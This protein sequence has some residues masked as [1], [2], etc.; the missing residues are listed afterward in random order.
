MSIARVGILGAG[1]WGTALA[2]S[3]IRAGSSVVLWT[4]AEHL[5]STI[6]QE[7]ENP[8]Y[9][10]GVALDAGIRATTDLAE[11]AACEALLL[12]VPAQHTRA[13]TERLAHVLRPDCPLVICAKGV[14]QGTRQLMTEL[15]STSL[16]GRP[17]AVLSG[18]TF[19]AEVA[20]GLPAAVTLACE[21]SQLGEDLIAALGSRSLRPYYSNDPLGAQLGGAVKN[22]MAI[23][24]GIVTGRKLGDNAR[25]ALVTRG[26]A[27]LMRLGRA[28]GANPA[29]LMGLSGL[30][31]L[32]LTCSAMQ[33]RN[34]SLGVAL[35]EGQTLESVLAER[36]TVA[37][38]VYS[39]AAVVALAERH[40]IDMPIVAAADQVLNH[41]AEID[42]TIAA[43]LARPFRSESH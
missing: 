31:D 33:S 14:E 22:V 35:G 4:R 1:A 21:E 17:L 19:A 34:Y 29:T 13:I 26:L 42:A 12:V 9:L 43:L 37:E 24:C 15:L 27:E 28:M 7:R 23:A 20:R 25:A 30:G 11:V 10:P 18:P 6:N 39:T 8:R 38:G 5:A 32:V 40:G 16:P 3:T 2:Q 36:H 41:G